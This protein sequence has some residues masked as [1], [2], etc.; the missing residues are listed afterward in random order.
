VLN[1]PVKAGLVDSWRNWQWNYLRKE[2]AIDSSTFDQ[3]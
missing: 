3:R 1:N 2:I